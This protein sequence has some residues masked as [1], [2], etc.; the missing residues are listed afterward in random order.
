MDIGKFVSWLI[1]L[2]IGYGGYK[3]FST[4][5]VTIVPPNP[6]T[7]E[8]LAGQAKFIIKKDPKNRLMAGKRCTRTGGGHIKQGIYSCEVLEFK[9]LSSYNSPLARYTIQLTKR[10]SQWRLQ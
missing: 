1:I 7:V 10:N 8:K 6:E 9:G 5:D 2:G 3:Y 4:G